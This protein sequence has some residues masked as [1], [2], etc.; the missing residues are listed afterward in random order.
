MKL[1]VKCPQCGGNNRF[2]LERLADGPICAACRQS[3]VGLVVKFE[4]QDFDYI[5]KHAPRPLLIDYYAPWCGPCRALG[6]VLE[7]IAARYRSRLIVAKLDIDSSPVLAER[8]A[9]RSVPTMQIF[10]RAKLVDTIVGAL[11][12]GDLDARLQKTLGRM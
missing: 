2:E 3:L 11:A 6:P 7:E 1:T 12:A 10:N 4:Q 8:F 9:I 5:V